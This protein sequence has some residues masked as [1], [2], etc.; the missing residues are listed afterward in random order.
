MIKMKTIRSG[1]FVFTLLLSLVPRPAAMNG[2]ADPVIVFLSD[3]GIADDSVSQCKGVIESAAPGTVVVD[4]THNVPPYDIRLAAFYLADSALVWPPG[5]VFLAIVDPGVGTSRKSA[6]LKTKSGH[7][8]VG[9][10]NGLFTLAA[11]RLGIEKIISIENRSFMRKTVTTT[12]HG[13]DVYSPVAARLAREPLILDRLGPPIT[14]PVMLDWPAPAVGT[15]TVTGAFL[16]VEIPYGNV[17]TD[18]DAAAAGQSG[19]TGGSIL[20]VKLK[21][22]VLTVPFVSTF[23]DVP[24][25][26]PL[27]YINSRGLLSFSLNMG[28]FSEKY[29]VRAGELVSVS[30][31]DSALTPGGR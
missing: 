30:I 7:F 13:R 21:D 26:E 2:A 12:F 22:R 3:F 15:G 28:D 17:W 11:R 27:A 14:A 6:V 4:M 23:G 31:Y 19:F 29:G 24:Q 9:P 16:R 5:T 10:D 1:A 8:F 20:A 25:G 18:I